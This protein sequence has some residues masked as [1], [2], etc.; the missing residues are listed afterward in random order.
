MNLRSLCMEC[1][2]R[3]SLP[4]AVCVKI[5][6]FWEEVSQ[7]KGVCVGP[8]ALANS[9]AKR[10][11]DPKAHFSLYTAAGCWG[12]TENIYTYLM[13]SSESHT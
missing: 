6:W 11:Y 7:V 13:C 4:I 3:T 9:S 2:S 5:C 1:W 12:G 10:G 8:S